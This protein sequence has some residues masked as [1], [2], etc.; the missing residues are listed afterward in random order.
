MNKHQWEK[1]N[2]KILKEE[3]LI[4]NFF[5]GR[6]QRHRQFD[7]CLG[8]Q[9]LYDQ[10]FREY[11][12]L[13]DIVIRAPHIIHLN[14]DWQISC[15]EGRRIVCFGGEEKRLFSPWENNCVTFFR[16]KY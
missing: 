15:C 14:T 10:L 12:I 13:C 16:T 1:N 2:D 9:L 7:H 6:D 5:N 11:L 3:R 8:M 4:G